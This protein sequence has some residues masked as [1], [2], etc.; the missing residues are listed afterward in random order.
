MTFG[1][2]FFFL[3]MLKGFGSQV[4]PSAGQAAG[5]TTSLCCCRHRITWSGSS[6]SAPPAAVFFCL[7]FPHSLAAR[8]L[9]HRLGRKLAGVVEVVVG[10]GSI[11]LRLL[12]GVLPTFLRAGGSCVQD[13]A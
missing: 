7:S 9:R 11:R 4:E 12:L 13:L 1:I 3:Y 8:C 5:A 2:Y 10:R 6:S